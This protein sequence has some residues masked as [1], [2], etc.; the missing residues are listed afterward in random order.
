MRLIVAVVSVCY[1][2]LVFA[3]SPPQNQQQQKDAYAACSDQMFHDP[4]HAVGTCK[5]YLAASPKGNP[6][7][8]KKVQDWLAYY[9]RVQPYVQFLKGLTVDSSGKWLVY[10]PDTTIDLPQTSQMQ[11][12][13][14]MQITRSFAGAKEELFLRQ[15]EA[16]YPEMRKMIRE[17]LRGPGL[18]EEELGA[19]KAPLWGGCNN[20]NIEAASVVT[21]R[22][23]RYFYDLTMTERKDP[24]LTSGFTAL[25]SSMEYNAGIKL[26]ARYTHGKDSFANVYVADMTLKWGFGC[27]GQCGVGWTRNKVVVLDA[28]CNVLALYLDAPVNNE[29]VVS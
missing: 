19:E 12:P 6:D 27:G 23:V 17:M 14:Q 15:A 3:Q 24:N 16:T 22:A 28:S 9:D 8:I 29:T 20:D 18:C 21:A 10:G 5:A 2:G 13:F 7:C 4:E 1:L 26:M 11:G 25:H